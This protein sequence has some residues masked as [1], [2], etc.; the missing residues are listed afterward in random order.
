A[1]ALLRTPSYPMEPEIPLTAEKHGES[2]T[3]R[4]DGTRETGV[5]EVRLRTTGGGERVAY[6]AVNADPAESNLASASETELQTAFAEEMP[7]EYVRDVSV[8]AARASDSRREYWWP[9]L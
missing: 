3:L 1:Q 4:Y 6:A 2:A 5:Y 8:L 9:L 7:Y